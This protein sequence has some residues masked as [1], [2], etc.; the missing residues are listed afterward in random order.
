MVA[1]FRCSTSDFSYVI[2]NGKRSFPEMIDH[3]V[4]KKPRDYSHP[5]F[6]KWARERIHEILCEYEISALGYKRAETNR[7]PE[8]ERLHLEGI[9]IE[10][11]CSLGIPTITN[12]LKSQIKKDL[13]FQR[14]ARYVSQII[15]SGPLSQDLNSPNLQEAALIALC[16]L[17][18]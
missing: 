11:A 2:L 9:L 12:K 7:R 1:G 4:R 10:C 15:S 5:E 16:L 17:E 6:L 18:R 3:G 8:E 13:G 14:E